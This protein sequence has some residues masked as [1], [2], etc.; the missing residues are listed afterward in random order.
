MADR[1]LISGLAPRY[2]FQKILTALPVRSNGLVADFDRG[3]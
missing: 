3:F 2:L 1:N